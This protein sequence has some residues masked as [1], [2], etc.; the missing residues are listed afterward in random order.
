MTAESYQLGSKDGESNE[1]ENCLH[2]REAFVHR[3]FVRRGQ[4]A[5]DELSLTS[6]LK[7]QEELP[8]NGCRWL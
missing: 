8:L 2:H 4:N 5:E 6:A 1:G 3:L 7:H